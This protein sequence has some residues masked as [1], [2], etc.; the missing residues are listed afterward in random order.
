MGVEKGRKLWRWICL[1][2]GITVVSRLQCS[3]IRREADRE[4]LQV[5]L[6][7]GYA[8]EIEYRRMD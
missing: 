2:E 7:W 4:G 8:V 6:G 5:G 1:L 3:Y